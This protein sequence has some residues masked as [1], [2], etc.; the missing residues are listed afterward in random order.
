MYTVLGQKIE[1]QFNPWLK[2]CATGLLQS[3]VPVR[4]SF[5]FHGN[6]V[7]GPILRKAN[8]VFVLLYLRQVEEVTALCAELVEEVAGLWAVQATEGLVITR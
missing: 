8:K 3:L 4:K 1:C 2:G 7:D 6:S 5:L